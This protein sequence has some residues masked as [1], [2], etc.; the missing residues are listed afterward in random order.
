LQGAEE[1]FK[2][3]RDMAA[4][5]GQTLSEGF[6]AVTETLSTWL[7]APFEEDEEEDLGRRRP[8]SSR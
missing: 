4:S 3:W 8:G 7:S 6:T 1:A 2:E 5:V